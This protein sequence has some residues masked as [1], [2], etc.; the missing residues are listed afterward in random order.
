MM[1]CPFFGALAGPHSAENT[2]RNDYGC[3][4][5]ALARA[6]VSPADAQANCPETGFASMACSQ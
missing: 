5:N 2:T 1:I 6:T 4:L 3:R